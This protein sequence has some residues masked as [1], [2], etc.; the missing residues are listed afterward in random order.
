MLPVCDVGVV[1]LQGTSRPYAAVCVVG[2]I[3]LQGTSRPYTA[4]VCYRSVS[5]Q[6]L[7]PQRHLLAGEGTSCL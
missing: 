1:Y 5:A 4:R 2:V 7:P 3:Y 6:S